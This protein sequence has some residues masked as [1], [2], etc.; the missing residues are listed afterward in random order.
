MLKLIALT[1]A[2][3]LSACVDESG[4]T[5]TDSG[6]GEVTELTR[7]APGDKSDDI[8]EDGARNIC[9]LLPTDGACAHACNP[10]K[11]MTFVPEGTC[12]VFVCELTDGTTYNTGG[13]N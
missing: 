12:A 5:S 8:E 13:C 11:M 1:A 4:P 2:L 9:D 6:D 7:Q 3:F 10:E